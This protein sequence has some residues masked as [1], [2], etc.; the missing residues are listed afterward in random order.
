MAR[1]TLTATEPGTASVT[2]TSGDGVD[3][4]TVSFVSAMSLEWIEPSGAYDYYLPALVT[5]GGSGFVSDVTATLSDGNQSVA[6]EDVIWGSAST[7]TATV[8]AG[9]AEGIYNLTVTAPGGD[10]VTLPNAFGVWYYWEG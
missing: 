3:S 5:I 1:T 2:A 7:L 10:N 6:L 8:P 9:T 4:A